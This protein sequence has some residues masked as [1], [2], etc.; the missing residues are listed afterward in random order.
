[1]GCSGHSIYVYL[2]EIAKTV[3]FLKTEVEIS[4][5]HQHVPIAIRG[6]VQR[7]TIAFVRVVE[8]RDE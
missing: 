1:M 6:K 7:I 2:E 4:G 8:D 5:N 3:R